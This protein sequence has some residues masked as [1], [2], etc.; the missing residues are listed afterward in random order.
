MTLRTY[1]NATST[2]LTRF[3]SKKIEE[4][5][6]CSFTTRLMSSQK[7]IVIDC[8][9][10]DQGNSGLDDPRCREN[11]FQ[12]IMKEPL[13]D[14]LVLS[15]LYERDYETDN[16][17]LLYMLA[18]FIDNLEVFRG[19]DVPAVCGRCL[20]NRREL[21]DKILEISSKDPVEGYLILARSIESDNHQCTNENDGNQCK[22][23]FISLLNKMR[24]NAERLSSYL[25]H[26]ISASSYY[27]KVMRPY[28]RPRFST[29]RIYTEPPD[30]AVFQEGYDVA[31]SGGRLM[32]VSIYSLTDRP[33]SLH[34]IIPPEYNMRPEELKLL[35]SV[36]QRLMRHR[37]EDLHFADP[38][39][40]REYF[41]RS[42]QQLLIQ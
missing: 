1:Q 11:I 18:G 42:S 19:I 32:E 7:S 36:R 41:R 2:I 39:N 40:S 30:N 15:N 13:V 22:T 37:P 4:N 9:G 17:E 6:L 8:R 23:N 35:E 29:S 16:L 5:R 38:A 28:T 24:G 33:E 3:L 21:I 27:S 12:I 26:N 31:R 20:D 10:C 25:H 34:F 14:R